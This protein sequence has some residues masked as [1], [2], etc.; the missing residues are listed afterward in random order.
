MHGTQQKKTH[1]PQS[2]YG[3]KQWSHPIKVKGQAIHEQG[4][5][6]FSLKSLR[7]IRSRKYIT[8][9]WLPQLTDNFDNRAIHSHSSL[10]TSHGQ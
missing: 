3:G 1:R 10:S 6:Y 2:T 7:A 4:Q 9:A 8:Q 5:R